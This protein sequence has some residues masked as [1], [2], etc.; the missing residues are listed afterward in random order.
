MWEF[1]WR[2]L[3]LLTKL[4]VRYLERDSH[5]ELLTVYSANQ[6]LIFKVVHYSFTQEMFADTREEKFHLVIS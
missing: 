4:N 1:S 6:S 5:L 2:V 3:V